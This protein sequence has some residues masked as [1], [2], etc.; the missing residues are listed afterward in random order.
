MGVSIL[1]YTSFFLNLHP[2]F[3]EHSFAV[4]QGFSVMILC[5]LCFG[6]TPSCLVLQT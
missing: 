1:I 4:K 3:Q 2:L 5:M 6:W